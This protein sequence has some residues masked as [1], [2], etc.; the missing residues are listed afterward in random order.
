MET[1]SECYISI[2]VFVYCDKKLSRFTKIIETSK[3]TKTI[4]TFKKIALKYLY[5]KRYEINKNIFLII[6][7]SIFQ[8]RI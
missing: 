6:K 7:E 5:Q 3:R 1:I 8:L 2:F 4:N